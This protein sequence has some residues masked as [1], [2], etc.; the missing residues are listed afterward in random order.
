MVE[1]ID[2]KQNQGNANKNAPLPLLI[3]AGVPGSIRKYKALKPAP[4]D[5]ENEGLLLYEFEGKNVLSKGKGLGGI[6][7]WNRNEIKHFNRNFIHIPKKPVSVQGSFA[8]DPAARHFAR[9]SEARS[10]RSELREIAATIVKEYRGI[11]VSSDF[12]WRNAAGRIVHFGLKAFMPEVYAAV[13]EAE[14]AQDIEQGT[15]AMNHFDAIQAIDRPIL[16]EHRVSEDDFRRMGKDSKTIIAELLQ[17]AYDA[18]ATN[19]FVLAQITVPEKAKNQLRLANHNAKDAVRLEI[20]GN[21]LTLYNQGFADYAKFLNA[22]PTITITD[23]ANVKGP[24]LFSDRYGNRAE[25]RYDGPEGT[26]TA[27]R[28]FTAAL[29]WAAEA[30]SQ[31]TFDGLVRSENKADGFRVRSHEALHNLAFVVEMMAAYRAELRLQQAA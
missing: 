24:V 16:I 3:F 9:R 2:F 7:R 29:V 11:N 25:I 13:G 14:S 10:A 30:L 1:L 5:L 28:I 12:N 4:L 22:P 8:F 17:A 23:L 19:K 15:Q 6:L 21:T 26:Q 31:K 18:S 20:R 27:A